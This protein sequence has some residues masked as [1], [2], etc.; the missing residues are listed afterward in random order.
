MKKTL[1]FAML[2]LAMAGTMNAQDVYAGGCK[3]FDD[4]GTRIPGVYKNG[5]LL[6]HDGEPG[7]GY[8]YD[9]YSMMAVD[10]ETQDVYWFSARQNSSYVYDRA[11]LWKNDEVYASFITIEDYAPDIEGFHFV[12]FN[13]TGHTAVI[14]AGFDN[15]ENGANL[16]DCATIWKDGERLY[17]PTLSEL[18]ASIAR[19]VVVVGDN[20]N[21]CDYYYCG[22]IY[23]S[24]WDPLIVVW[25]N[26]EMLYQL[27][28]TE[29]YT[30]KIDYCD[31][32]LYTLGVEYNPETDC[33]RSVVWMWDQ[34]LYIMEMENHTVWAESMVIESG[35]VWVITRT[36]EMG[37]ISKN[38]VPYDI[39]IWK[40][41]EVVYTHNFPGYVF[42]RGLD[43]TSNGVYYTIDNDVYKD[44][45]VLF[46]YEDRVELLNMQVIESLSVNETAASTFSVY[47]NP[48]TD[49][50]RIE[51]GSDEAVA[52]YNATGQLVMSVGA[53]DGN[54]SVSGLPTGLYLLKHGGKTAQFIKE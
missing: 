34:P 47:P 21:D 2:L 39:T 3:I 46:T 48:A 18:K 24:D 27:T 28:E 1:L 23:N 35:N 33:D 15:Y 43:V 8:Q 26:N 4:K 25:H 53:T 51:N 50:I 5:T 13:D 11:C 6:Y 14:T 19:D 45:E 29:S 44:G 52:I 17:A 37:G 40:N 30:Y 7:D 31:G 54:I 16:L 41:G 38:D 32:N 9:S 22:E 20:E 12:R 36:H 49:I 42:I 10:P